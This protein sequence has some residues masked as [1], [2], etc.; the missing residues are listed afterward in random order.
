MVGVVVKTL[1]HIS[2]VTKKIFYSYNLFKMALGDVNR[3]VLDSD[4][5][6]FSPRPCSE[7]ELEY[8]NCH[9]Y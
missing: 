4:V 3:D 8:G 5:S 1:V 2:P 7:M 6:N 9:L